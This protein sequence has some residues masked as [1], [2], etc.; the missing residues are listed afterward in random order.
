MFPIPKSGKYLDFNFYSV[1]N[2]C[3]LRPDMAIIDTAKVISKRIEKTPGHLVD[4]TVYYNIDVNNLQ[5]WV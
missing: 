1:K 3:A 4:V 2:Y 5:E